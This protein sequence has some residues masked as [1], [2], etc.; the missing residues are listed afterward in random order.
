MAHQA[1]DA[2]VAVQERVNVVEPVMG[3]GDRQ[4]AAAHPERLEAVA[5][6]EMRHEGFDAVGRR[7]L[8]TADRDLMIA[9]AE[10]NSPGIMRTCARPPRSISIAS[11][12][13]S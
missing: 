13:S 4:D 1:A 12:A 6:L 11:G 3:R 5:P 2:P 9:R 10:R 7:R 8:V